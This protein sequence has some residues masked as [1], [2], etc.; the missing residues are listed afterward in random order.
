MYVSYYDVLSELYKSLGN[1]HTW[2]RGCSIDEVKYD[3]NY[4]GP[5]PEADELLFVSGF[6][7]KKQYW[8]NKFSDFYYFKPMELLSKHE[9]ASCKIVHPEFYVL[10]DDY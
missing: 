8:S 1:F 3:Y 7:I 4:H 6:L 9:K 5:L 2:T 10:Y